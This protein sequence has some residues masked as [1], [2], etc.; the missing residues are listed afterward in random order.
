MSVVNGTPQL[1]CP[2]NNVIKANGFR[3]LM[4]RKEGT[5]VSLSCDYM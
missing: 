5:M 2:H 1:F 4:E 3:P